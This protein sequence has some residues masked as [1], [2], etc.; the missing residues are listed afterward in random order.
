[1]RRRTDSRKTVREKRRSVLIILLVVLG[2]CGGASWFYYSPG[3]V[4]KVKGLLG[5]DASK[6]VE[7]QPVRGSIFD[8]NYKGLAISLE[9]VG[10]Y[11]RTRELG[12]L[13]FVA[14][15]LA[16]VLEMEETH[17][18]NSLKEGGLRIWLMKDISQEQEDSIRVLNLPGVYLHKDFSRFYP[19]KTVAAHL[20]GFADNGI[21]L[22]GVEYYYDRLV[23]E[24]LSGDTEG[25]YKG[26]GGQHLLLTLDLKIQRIMEELVFELSKKQPKSRI[27]IYA[28][29]A[30]SGSIIA[31]S[32]FPSFNPNT[33]RIYSQDILENLLLEPMVVPKMY[34]Q[35]L[36][37]GASIKSQYDTRGNVLPWSI[38]TGN[39][40]LGTELRLWDSLGFDSRP[41]EDFGASQST[42][43]GA[44]GAR[45]IDRWDESLF[46]TVPQMLTPLNMLTGMSCLLNGGTKINGHIVGSIVDPVTEHE[47]KVNSAQEPAGVGIVST[48]VSREISQLVSSFAAANDLGGAMIEDEAIGVFQSGDKWTLMTNK[49]L[50]AAV[51]LRDAELTILMTIQE[52]GVR[53]SPGTGGSMSPPAEM[54]SLVLPRIAVLEQVGRG[55]QQ[56]AELEEQESGNFPA[57]LDSIRDALQASMM[58]GSRQLS[59]SGVMPDMVGLSLRKSLRLLQEANC[60]IRIYGTGHVV[61]QEP[62]PGTRLNRDDE[63][64]LKLRQEDVSVELYEKNTLIQ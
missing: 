56:V 16:P 37:G 63:C 31:A 29:N 8:R 47:S 53:T 52:D 32:Q 46:G 49:V 39:H 58:S 55:L 11:V 3:G 7:E 4:T 40:N 62:K 20:V 59:K 61:S 50:F 45:L 2:F 18:L 1:M 23:Q 12:S 14:E 30:K 21:G 9:R 38:S 35:I 36:H 5:G 44:Q 60:T 15:K 17:L 42:V 48:E 33:Y 26:T 54:L 13:E 27:G 51:P 34:R 28:M 64:V 25:N 57:S 43:S 19:Q 24:V 10:V 6:E 41:S 22:A